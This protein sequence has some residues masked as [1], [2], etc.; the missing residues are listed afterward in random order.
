MSQSHTSMTCFETCPRQY[1]ARYVTQEVKFEQ[2]IEAAW[3]DKVHKVPDWW[4]DS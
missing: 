4:M 2:G 1:E 3:G